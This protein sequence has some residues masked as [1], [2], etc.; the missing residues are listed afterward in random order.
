[1]IITCHLLFG[2]AIAQKTQNPALGLFFA[3]LSHFLLDFIPHQEYG[4][5]FKQKFW[6]AP[7]LDFLKVGADF[8]LGILVISAI[9]KNMI[10]ALA[11]GF[12]AIIPD[13]IAV[14]YFVLPENRIMKIYYDFHGGKIHYFKN[15]IPALWGILSQVAVI[16]VSI[17]FLLQ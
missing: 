14:L 10:L 2:A 8:L 15:K 12:A 11:G 4:V 3:F 5:N 17:F 16:S 6:K 13:V 7:L 9:N 1:M